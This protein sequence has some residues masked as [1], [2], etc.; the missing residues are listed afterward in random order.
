VEGITL[1][2]YFF[3]DVPRPSPNLI[4]MD[5][6][7][8]GVEALPGCERCIRAKRPVILIES[9]TPQEDRAIS[10]VILGHGYCAYR[11][12]E[13]KW[14]EAPGEVHPDPRGVW[15]TLLLFPAESEER[16][17]QLIAKARAGR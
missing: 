1:D 3:G 8:G 17:R 10:D 16:F 12:N 6:E 9:H 15:G 2:D 11:M 4:K 13:G 7:G 5:I 14:V